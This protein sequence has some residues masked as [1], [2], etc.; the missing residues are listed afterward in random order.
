MNSGEG[1][2]IY[3]EISRES[4]LSSSLFSKLSLSLSL[5]SSFCLFF[6][7][8]SRS[9]SF[10][11][12]L[13]CF[14]LAHGVQAAKALFF[15]SIS[16]SSPGSRERVKLPAPD[17]APLFG[18]LMGASE[19]D[20]DARCVEKKTPLQGLGPRPTK[21]NKPSNSICLPSIGILRSTQLLRSSP[22]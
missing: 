9:R 11:I 22:C 19:K 6:C 15:L 3:R 16:S 8:L 4:E 20:I 5:S 21:L 17:G 14:G 12:A 13:L 18:G 1:Y 2:W 7:S 10:F